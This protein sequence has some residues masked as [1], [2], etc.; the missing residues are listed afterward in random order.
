MP[1]LP[2]WKDT[3]QPGT[4]RP[5]DGRVIT[6]TAAQVVEAEANVRKMLRA[7]LSIPI[8]DRHQP[9]EAGDPDA[10][11]RAFRSST[12]GRVAGCE[13]DGRNTLWLALSVPSVGDRHRLQ[14]ARFVSPKLHEHGYTD[15][16]GIWYPGLCVTHVAATKTPVI[17]D[18][19]VIDL[20]ATR[21]PSA[22]AA[23]LGELIDSLRRRGF[24]IP[25][26]VR[27]LND[28]AIAIQASGRPGG[29][30]KPAR[31]DEQ[32]WLDGPDLADQ[33]GPN[34][35]MRMSATGYRRRPAPAANAAIAKRAE[36]ARRLSRGC[37]T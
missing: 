36:L 9:V 18:Q 6:V 12:L 7:G 13:R 34:A 24:V 21:P 2:I 22:T 19:Q 15:H 30:R 14:A 3:L 8:L 17:Q 29:R 32:D 20:S 5:S 4:W 16:R 11:K 27:D 33:V 25:E 1:L 10:T 23:D 26:G 37:A 28:L 31:D 35:P